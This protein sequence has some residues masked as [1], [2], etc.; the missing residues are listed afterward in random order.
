MVSRRLV[1]LGPPGAGKGTQASRLS[2]R[3]GLAAL[4]SGDTLR[5]EIRKGS[6]VGRQAEKYVSAG[7]LVPDDVIT[8]VMLA[9]IREIGPG[10]GFILDGFPRTVP[11]AEALEAGLAADGHRLDAV[12]DFHVAD[13]TIVERIA[14]RRI[15][16][17]CGRLYNVRFF[18]PPEDGRCRTCGGQVIQRVDDREDVVVTRLATYRRETEPLIEFYRD[19]G[20]LVSVDA[21]APPDEV[22]A[23]V[24]RLVAGPDAER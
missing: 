3:L 9:A 8:G 5:E 13:E 14:R 11:Q 19:R 23:A 22:E 18:P 2:Q 15:C 7:K 17:Q 1:F 10:R 6:Q 24:V 21:G 20:L 12:V 4:A 16:S